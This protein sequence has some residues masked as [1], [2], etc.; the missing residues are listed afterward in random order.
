MNI[1][2]TRSQMIPR[3]IPEFPEWLG[4]TPGSPTT[5]S[6]GPGLQKGQADSDAK[7]EAAIKCLLRQ[8][9]KNRKKGNQPEKGLERQQ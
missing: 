7:A 4:P 9:F 6:G 3:D 8:L 5:G 1:V 2:A